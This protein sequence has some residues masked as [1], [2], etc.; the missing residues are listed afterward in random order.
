MALAL[1]GASEL[2]TVLGPSLFKTVTFRKETTMPRK[3]AASLAVARPE[4]GNKASPPHALSERQR[5]LWLQ[6]VSAKPADWFSP[7][8]HP[9]LAA[10]VAHIETFELLEREF[11][12]LDKVD[13]AERLVWLDRLSK[14]RERESRAIATLSTKLRLTN[15]S[16]Y[17]PKAAGTASR[18]TGPA[19][20]ETKGGAR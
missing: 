17:T 11:R 5:A 10:L 14:L 2:D 1:S 20:W 9:M 7:E 19:P 6:I 18:R 12:G 3:S 8:T 13:T 16:R 15:Q 4:L